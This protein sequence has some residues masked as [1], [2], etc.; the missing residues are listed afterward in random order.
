MS[1]ETCGSKC[2]AEKPCGLYIFDIH[3]DGW[4]NKCNMIMR[5]CKKCKAYHHL[6][7]FI[8]EHDNNNKWDKNATKRVVL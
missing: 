7:T 5:W 3:P 4:C 1:C 6:G 8:D 2:K